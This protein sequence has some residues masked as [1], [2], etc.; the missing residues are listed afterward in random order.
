M[1]DAKGQQQP[2]RFYIHPH[3]LSHTHTISLTCASALSRTNARPTHTHTRTHTY[4]HAHDHLQGDGRQCLVRWDNGN[5]NEYAIG[6]G[7]LY[8]LEGA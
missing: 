8:D 3:Y 7:G 1:H 2:N 4:T 5:E 6:Y